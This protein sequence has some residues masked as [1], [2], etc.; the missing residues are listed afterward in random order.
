MLSEREAFEFYAAKAPVY[1]RC[2]RGDRL[3]RQHLNSVRHRFWPALQVAERDA[4]VAA[5]EHARAGEG[6]AEFDEVC[7]RIRARLWP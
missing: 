3:P 2:G 5:A 1:Q 4:L 7:A 6:R